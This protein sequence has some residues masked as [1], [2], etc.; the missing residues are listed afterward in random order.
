MSVYVVGQ[1]RIH[2]PARYSGYTT[3]FRSQF[4]GFPGECWLPTN[5]RRFLRVIGRGPRRSF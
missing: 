3:T 2:D 4:P 5:R 1:V